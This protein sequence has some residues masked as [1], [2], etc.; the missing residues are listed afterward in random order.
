MRSTQTSGRGSGASD[1]SVLVS[2]RRSWRP[3]RWTCSPDV[4][5]ASVQVDQL[6][7]EPEQF[8][9]AQAEDQ[10]Q[11]VGRVQHIVIAAGGFQELAC[12]IDGPGPALALG[13]AAAGQPDDGGRVAGDDLFL[14]GAGE[15]SPQCVTRVLAGPGGQDLVAA[16]SGGAA[17]ALAFWPVGVLA[18]CAALADAA[19]LVEPLPDVFDLELVQPLVAEVRNDVQPGEQLVLSRMS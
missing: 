6:P 17:A 14:D 3:T 16:G 12:L 10:D 15:R 2:R 8:S 13:V 9:F 4:Q 7:G 1:V 18:L 5:L 11:D 19:E